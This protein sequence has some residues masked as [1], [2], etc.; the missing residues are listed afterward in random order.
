MG[1]YALGSVFAPASVALVGGSPRERSLGRLVLRQVIDGGF[2]G[3][4]GV[5]NKRY[6]ELEGVATAPRLDALGFAPELVLVATPP[7]TVARVAL[8]AADAG[9]RAL[10]VLT[11]DMG[12]GPG[13]HNEALQAIARERGLRVVGPNCLGVIAPHS[14]LFASFAAHR[15]PAGDLALVS[16]SGAIGAAMIEWASARGLGFSAVVSLGDAVD[17]D[18]GDLLDWFATDRHTRA[19]LLYLERVRDARK[20]LSAA[21]AAARGKPVVVVRPGRH[22]RREGPLATHA[23]TLATPDAVYDAAFRRAGLLR[24]HALDE[25]FAAAETLS[26]LGSVPGKRLAVLTNGAGTGL[27]ALDRLQDL[28]GMPAK[29]ADAT[30]ARLDGELARG[31]SRSNP[32]D[33]LGDADG[34]RYAAGLAALLDDPGNDA[35]LAVNVPTVLSDPLETAEATVRVLAARPRGAAKKPV[36]ALWLGDDRGASELLGGAGVPTYASEAEAVRGFMYLVRHRE[37]QA[38]LMETPPSLPED[39]AVDRDAA[40]ALVARA[41]AEGREWL[42]PEAT[43]RLLAAYGI[44]IATPV[45]AA[46]PEAAVA[47]AQPLLAGGGTVAVKVLSPDIAHKSDVDGVRLHLNS[48]AAVH[49]AAAE[50]I[51]RARA[52]RP[53][54]R[55]DGVSVHPMVLRAKAR[56]VIA[57]IAD[58][59]VFGPVV[60]FGRGGT[61]VELIDDKALALPPLDLRLAHELIGRTRVSRILRAYRDVPA[62]DERALALVLV[63]LAQLAADIPE[64]REVDINPLLVDAGGAVA[65]DA[66]IALAPSRRL[67]RG[68][69]H[70][71]F[72]VFPYPTELE[73]T[74]QLSNGRAAFVRPVRPEDDAMFRRF[75]EHVSA[76]DLR[77]RFFRAVRDFSHD[78]IARLVQLDYARSM[79]LVA[80]DVESGDMLGAVRLLADSDFRRGEY[81]IMVRSDLKGAGLGWKLMQEMIGVARWMGLEMIEGQVLRENSTML[82]MCRRLGFKV[83]PD[84]DDATLMLVTLPVAPPHPL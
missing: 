21:R 83:V 11:R 38:A 1:T 71:R 20:F 32:V 65:L 67:H 75:F 29:L 60:V 10:I 80:I 39:F 5:V 64:V 35:V 45:L 13:S 82:A 26:H 51:A 76:D 48:A 19:I 69:G 28:G 14:K 34:E 53:G 40:Q 56:E 8:R 73:R 30:V 42:D 78:F 44:D 63:K 81:G 17:V 36:L 43:A 22:A 9:A 54:A 23:A 12:E 77:L 25:L 68:R 66:R 52:L 16:Q 79:A 84:P 49:E 58:D 15:P 50:I 2:H 18:F 33:L 41:L 59:P 7:A 31:W 62:A 70:P 57:G 6:P 55:I 61:A 46:S 27:L 4:I 24:V 3:R 37:A 47:A 74:L 72:A